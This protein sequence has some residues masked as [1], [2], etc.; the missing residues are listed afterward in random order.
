MYEPREGYHMMRVE[1]GELEEALGEREVR[2]EPVTGVEFLRVQGVQGLHYKG[3]VR[4]RRGCMQGRIGT[5][6]MMGA[7]GGWNAYM[8]RRGEGEE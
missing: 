2:R 7:R 6:R 3:C 5:Y 8:R 1:A 4:W